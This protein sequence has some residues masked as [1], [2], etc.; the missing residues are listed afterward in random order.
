MNRLNSKRVTAV[1]AMATAVFLTA[2]LTYVVPSSAAA[3]PDRGPGRGQD[4]DE[5]RSNND[6]ARSKIH[7]KLVE[8]ME[9][10]SVEDVPVFATVS[11]DP[12]AAV[13]Q[14][15]DAKVAHEVGAGLVVGTITVQ[16]LPKLATADG[17]VAVGP[18]DFAQT[19]QD[20]KSVV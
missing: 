9:S 6:H 19:G 4:P 11:G 1:L 13:A 18:I 15:E 16:A 10:G 5:V 20:R 3:P 12:S 14:L 8:Q 7:P 17:V 2:A